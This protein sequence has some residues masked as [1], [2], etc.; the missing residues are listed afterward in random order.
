MSNAAWGVAALRGPAGVWWTAL[1][2]VALIGA[3]LRLRQIDESLWLDELHTA[4]CALA[5]LHEVAARAADGNQG[6]LFFWWQ[7]GLVQLLGASEPTLRLTSVVAGTG[8]L[9][10]V[11]VWVARHGSPLA[12]W[13]AAA[14]VAVDPWAIF[15]ATEARAYALVQCLGAVHL[16]GTGTLLTRP[17]RGFRLAWVVLGA[18]LF[19]LH[20]TAVMLFAAELVLAG[21]WWGLWPQQV[22][23]RLAHAVWDLLALLLLL[24]PAAGT[25]AVISGR[26]ANWAAFVEP[27][28]YYA[29]FTWW[30]LGLG[31]GF[32]LAAAAVQR[33]LQITGREGEE[34][35][36]RGPSPAALATV[37]CWLLVPAAFAWLSTETD[38]A[39][40]FFPRYLAACA[41]AAVILGA[42]TV[43]LAPGRWS[44]LLVAGLLVGAAV[45]AS[46]IFPRLSASERPL[47][48]RREDWRAAVAWLNAQYA[49]HPR[50]V[51]LSS[52]LIEADVLRETPSPRE[53]A[54]CRFPLRSLYPLAA[55]DAQVIPLPRRRPRQN[56]LLPPVRERLH[57]EGGCWVVVRGSPE[58]ARWVAVRL[59]AELNGQLLGPAGR[60]LFDEDEEES[61]LPGGRPFRWRV[62]QRE[63]FGDL[64]VWRFAR[65]PA[66]VSHPTPRP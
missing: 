13:V 8:L 11:G 66:R 23:Y 10:L 48:H 14:L 18:A 12:G 61:S 55:D 60:P 28:P 19:H 20:Y 50:P 33:G 53:V 34:D 4:W 49:G 9:I 63:D 16:L 25:L 42:W 30:P 27:Q 58:R 2:V 47:A 32:V 38:L 22:R 35:V 54:Y 37:I 24:W 59:I 56:Y 39:R 65:V 40:L 36:S 41:P 31:L 46:G 17:S 43:D 3:G 7:W 29:L 5:P 45:H 44:R 62:V 52:G 51:L 64:S 15:W 26:R 21:L 6:P 1:G 57:E